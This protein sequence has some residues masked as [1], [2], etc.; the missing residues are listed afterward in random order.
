ML[1]GRQGRPGM[2]RTGEWTQPPHTSLSVT[3]SQVCQGWNAAQCEGWGYWQKEWSST[4]KDEEIGRG[5]LKKP[6]IRQWLHHKDFSTVLTLVGNFWNQT[7]HEISSKHQSHQDPQLIGSF[8]IH[9]MVNTIIT[10]TK[11][12]NKYTGHECASGLPATWE[13]E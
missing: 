8:I 12:N 1:K 6:L 10:I 11:Q 3:T 4:T 9:K 7:Q 13:A 5:N 2:L